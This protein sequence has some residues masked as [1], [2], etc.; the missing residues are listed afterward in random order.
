M[1]VNHNLQASCIRPIQSLAQHFI[2]TLHVWLAIDW[3]HT[4]V[5][6]WDSHMVQFGGRHLGEI[7]RGDPAIPVILQQRLRGV[8]AQLL[9]Q[10][11]FIDCVIAFEDGWCDPGFE[12]EPTTS[13]NTTDL[14]A[15]VVKLEVALDMLS[16]IMLAWKEREE[17][18]ET[19][20]EEK[21]SS[22]LAGSWPQQ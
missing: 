1:Q 10:C 6:D 20:T 15:I 3:G 8:F 13:V 2:C 19:H 4:P 12:N 22:K 14:L 7:V 5:P 16:K 17:H 18:V 9:R 21:P 11:V